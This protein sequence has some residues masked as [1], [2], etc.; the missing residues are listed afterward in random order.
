MT[1][2]LA[3]PRT[4]VIKKINSL[5]AEKHRIILFTARG[6]NT[7]DGNV[8]LIESELR[9]LTEKWLTDNRVCYD[10]LIFG[11]P[12]ADYYVDDKNLDVFNFL[13]KS[14]QIFMQK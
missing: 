9:S 5:Y 2:H 10:E 3:E 8:D 13:Y 12:P 6:M 14:E 7:Y 4:D 1:Y 11:K